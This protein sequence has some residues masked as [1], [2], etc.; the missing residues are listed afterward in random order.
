MVRH[1]CEKYGFRAL[2]GDTDGFNFAFPDNID[3][4]KYVAK[5]SHWKTEDD[6]GKEL[7]GLDAVLAEFNENYMIGRMGLDIDDI[8]DSTINF[9]RKNYANKINGKIKLVGNS[10]KSKKMSAFI[11]D[12]LKVAIEMLLDGDGYSFVKHYHDYVDKIYNY[13]IPLVKI[14]SKS[15]VKSTIE[16]YKKKASKKNKAGNPMP[17]QAHMEL[18]IKENIKVNLGDTLFYVNIGKTKTDGDLKTYVK[19]KMKKRELEKYIETYGEAPKSEITVQLNSKLIDPL[20]VERD[21]ESIKE[22]EVLK[23]L[24]S[25]IDEND[26][27][28]NET[29]KR[30]DELNSSLYTDEYNVAKYLNSFNKKVK[31]LLVCFHPD[32]RD[33]ILLDI[34]KVKDENGKKSIEKLQEKTFF[35]KSE[36]ELISGMPFKAIDQWKIK[37]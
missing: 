9:S 23:K 13:Q 2:V 29:L 31:P 8:C 1:F 10:I 33:K 22:L 36:C 24:L 28:R 26:P 4:I 18:V 12:F 25:N 14:A 34:K 5:G 20:V 19:S 32:I 30:I 17:K 35:T 21:F 15:K 11:E 6:A 27:Q 3:E 37:K 7:I 16:D